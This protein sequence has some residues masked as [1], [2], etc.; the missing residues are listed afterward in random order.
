LNQKMLSTIS[1]ALAVVALAATCSNKEFDQCGGKSFS[2]DKCCQ[3][4][5][6]CTVINDYFSQCQP[7]DLCMTG[8]Y[9][10][11]AGMDPDTHAPIDKK[12]MCCPPSFDCTFQNTYYSQCMPTT[13][14][15]KCAKPYT[16]CGGQDPDGNPWG[17]KPEDKTCCND[18]F[19]CDVVKPKY[20]SIC[21]PVPRCLNPRYGQC[22][23][24]DQKGNPWT[25]DFKHDDCCPEPFTCVY[26]SKYFSQCQPNVTTV[27]AA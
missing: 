14:P 6:N 11:C 2:G 1:A 9:G 27:E 19:E 3:E 20:F 8:M 26:Q 18:G 12:K 17:T 15:T 16:Q 5:D 21:N 22:G 4:Y 25:K 7:K 10:Q 23:G 24:V 13:K